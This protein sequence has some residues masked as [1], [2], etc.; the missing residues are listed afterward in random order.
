MLLTSSCENKLELVSQEIAKGRISAIDEGSQASSRFVT[1]PT[2]WI[3]TTKSTVEVGH[4]PFE[5]L[6]NFKVG[7]TCFVVIQKYKDNE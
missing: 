5:F 7:D 6:N 1:Y 4:I 2:I 3:Q